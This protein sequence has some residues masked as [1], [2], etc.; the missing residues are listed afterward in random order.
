VTYDY[1]I[2]NIVVVNLL[3]AGY[4]LSQQWSPTRWSWT[5]LQL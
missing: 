4:T 2:V 3:L 1:H 5:L